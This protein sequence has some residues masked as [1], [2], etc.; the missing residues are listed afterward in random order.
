M[1]LVNMPVTYT[2]NCVQGPTR[3][4]SNKAPR[5][6]TW[7]WF[8][9]PAWWKKRI[10]ISNLSSDFHMASWHMTSSSGLQESAGTYTH[11]AHMCTPYS[12]TD[13]LSLTHTYTRI[14]GMDLL[15]IISRRCTCFM[16]HQRV[17]KNW[18][19]NI[20]ERVCL[21]S[22]NWKCNITERVCLFFLLTSS[23]TQLYFVLH[24]SRIQINPLY[25]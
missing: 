12:Y 9:E 25:L 19:C 1:I 17:N 14:I 13:I 3:L 6:G 18:K 21:F 22:I 4:F 7:V 8:R 23:R 11:T 20:T 16:T 2:V 15:P 24:N 5:L 10:N